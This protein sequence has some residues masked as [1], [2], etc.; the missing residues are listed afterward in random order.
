MINEN[1][2][3]EGELF[4]ESLREHGVA[5]LV[6]SKTAGEALAANRFPLADGSQL[7]VTTEVVM[8][9]QGR[10]LNGTGASPDLPV[11]LDP[12]AL[13]EGR[14]TQLEAALTYLRG[15]LGQ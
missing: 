9:G 12:A 13:L 15:K 6:G 4:A 11:E 2:R 8:T 3:G 7:L 1:S 5:Y 10:D 14:D